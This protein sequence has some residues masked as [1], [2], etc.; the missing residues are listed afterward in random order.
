MDLTCSMLP[1]HGSTNYRNLCATQLI[2]RYKPRVPLFP[3]HRDS[4]GT[5]D[6][7]Y[8]KRAFIIAAIQMWPPYIL[9]GTPLLPNPHDGTITKRKWEMLIWELK[10]MLYWRDYRRRQ[11]NN[12]C[13]SPGYAFAGSPSL[14]DPFDDNINE[15][16][17]E[18]I[19]ET[20]QGRIRSR[21]HRRDSVQQLAQ[22]REYILVGSPSLPDPFDDTINEK[23]WE[24]LMETVQARLRGMEHRRKG[25][26][27][28]G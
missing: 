17:W 9:N 16:Q 3:E 2:A 21:V 25:V 10:A 6:A 27:K 11:V 20:V 8:P 12:I 18:H 24:H 14:P 19:M 7:Q 4:P 13:E 1:A 23:Q 15:E 28:S 22:K 26:R 5:P